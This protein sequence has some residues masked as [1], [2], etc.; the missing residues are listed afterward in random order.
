M[1]VHSRIAEV[2]QQVARDVK[3]GNIY[4][5]RNLIGAV[6]GVQPFGGRGLSGTGPKAGGPFYLTRLVKDNLQVIE[7][8]LSD[9]KRQQLLGASGHDTTVNSLLQQAATAQPAWAMLDITKRSS[10][11]RQFLAQ[12]ASNSIVVKQEQDLPQVIETA[13]G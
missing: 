3:A 2:T 7:A 8:E 6:V 1:G 4:I 5:N 9:A 11:I 10:V 12:L 13:R